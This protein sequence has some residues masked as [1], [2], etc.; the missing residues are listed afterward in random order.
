LALSQPGL[1]QAQIKALFRA[2][3]RLLKEN[4]SLTPPEI[5]IPM[6]MDRRELKI[7]R[8]GKYVYGKEIPGIQSLADEVAQEAELSHIPHKVGVKIDMPASALQAGQMAKYADFLLFD[9][10]SLTE[11]SFVFSKTHAGDYLYHYSDLDILA[12]TSF[13]KLRDEIKELVTLACA[14]ARMIRPDIK[15]AL[16][17]SGQNPQD[18]LSFSEELNL[19]FIA[20]PVHSL[21]IFQ[22]LLAQSAIRAKEKPQTSPE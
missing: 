17:D 13:S 11:H 16:S 14:R 20:C 7:L 10:D 18:S 1:F 15:L 3:S 9:T 4:K 6:I 12:D 19:D 22:C 8:F 21:P 2:Q 5:S